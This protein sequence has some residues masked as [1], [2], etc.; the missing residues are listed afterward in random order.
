MPYFTSSPPV[1]ARIIFWLAG[2]FL[3]P[4]LSLAA[5]VDAH[6]WELAADRLTRTENPPTIIAEGNV[7]LEKKPAAQDNQSGAVNKSVTT[8]K[9]DWISYDL[10]KGLLT[11]KG[12]VLIDVGPDRLMADSGT[13]DLEKTTGTFNN[14]TVVLQ[15]KDTHFKGQVIEKTGA[16]TYRIEDGWVITCKLEPGQVPPWSFAAGDIAITDGGYAFLTNATFRVKDVPIL[17]SPVMLLP[18]KRERQTGL[19]FPTFSF[20]SRDGFSAETPLFINLSPSMDMTWYPRYFANRGFMNGVEFR[21]ITD[22]RSTGMLMGNF[23]SDRLS[24]PSEVGYYRD[25]DF[26]HTNSD[27][28]W[29]RGKADQNIGSWVTRLD[30]DVASDLDYLREFNSGNTGF[31]ASQARFTEIFGRGFADKTNKYRENTLAAL[32][33]YDNGTSLLAEAKAVNDITEQVYTPDNPSQPWT[34]PSLT[35]SG[36]LP[37]GSVGGP[38]FLWNANYSNFWRDKGVNAQR[39]D[40]MPM[41]STGIPLSR[42]IEANVTGGVR[43]TS[44]LIDGNG[45]SAW[46][47]NDSTNRFLAN[48]NSEVGTTLMRDFSFNIGDASSLSHI[49]RPF[50]AYTRTSIPDKKDLPQFDDIDQLEEENAVY[51]GFNN[52]FSVSGQRNGHEYDRDLAFFKIKEGYDLRS[53]ASNTPLTPIIIE[54]GAYPVEQMRLKYT[55]N[56]DVYGDGAFLHSIDGDYYSQRGDKFSLDY[57]YNEKTD[58]NSVRGSFWYLLPYNFAAGYSLERAIE[59]SE[60]IQEIYRL[61]FI[62]PC[63]SVELSANNTPGDQTVMFTFRLANIGNPLGFGL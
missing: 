17:Y 61:R 24:D 35:Y 53:E 34:L 7:L 47:D 32:R 45:S 39:V 63:W 56:I 29:I 27:R 54:T 57:R 8:V 55:T 1:F 2:F 37:V 15:E 62:Q 19:L 52:F 21:Y 14:A 48:L 49:L 18:A 33:S 4:S 58:V 41:L 59:Q 31:D 6:Q 40:L 43:N 60:T 38:D 44:Y 50:V 9:A 51:L 42:Y 22:D 16:L 36:A 23:L 26:T 20:S 3:C 5:V 28:Y 46:E 12:H 13:I 25:G 11:A 10:T 30:I